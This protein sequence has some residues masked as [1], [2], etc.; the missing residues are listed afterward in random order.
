ML[1]SPIIIIIF[2]IIGNE[3]PK[4]LCALDTLQ[5][6]NCFRQAA[7]V[8]TCSERWGSS[9]S[10]EV[11][12]PQSCWASL[13]TPYEWCMAGWSLVLCADSEGVNNRS[14]RSTWELIKGTIITLTSASPFWCPQKWRKQ[15]SLNEKVLMCVCICVLCKKDYFTFGICPN[16]LSDGSEG[17][18]G[19]SKWSDHWEL[20]PT[21]W[22]S[23]SS[24][25]LVHLLCQ[26]LKLPLLVEDLSI[27]KTHHLERGGW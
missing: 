3:W 11:R 25:F 24:R 21:V 23:C 17:N 19:A 1:L 8:I 27:R 20:W 26:T 5:L 9:L 12:Q 6:N 2:T 22:E 7:E 4:L 18:S 15:P 14:H 13:Y 16:C 10:L